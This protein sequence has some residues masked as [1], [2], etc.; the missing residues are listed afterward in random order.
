[1]QTNFIYGVIGGLDVYGSRLH[2]DRIQFLAS[3][4]GNGPVPARGSAVELY[5]PTQIANC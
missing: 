4:P 3:S 2:D 1:M 5:R